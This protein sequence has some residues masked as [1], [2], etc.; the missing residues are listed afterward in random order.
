VN[1]ITPA[2]DFK[3]VFNAFAEGGCRAAVWGGEVRDAVLG[4]ESMDT[5]VGWF[6][7][8]DS[9]LEVLKKNKWGGKFKKQGTCPDVQELSEHNLTCQARDTPNSYV[10][11]GHPSVS[12]EGFE[13]K[14]ASENVNGPD[15]SREFTTNAMAYDPLHAVVI[16]PTGS[17]LCD[18]LSKRVAV[19]G[20]H[21]EGEHTLDLQNVSNFEEWNNGLDKMMRVLK[22]VIPPKSFCI[23]HQTF[24]LVGIDLFL[25]MSSFSNN[26]VEKAL[27]D[28][29]SHYQSR[30]KQLEKYAIQLFWKFCR[31]IESLRNELPAFLQESLKQSSRVCTAVSKLTLINIDKE[32]Q[33]KIL[34]PTSA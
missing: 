30:S 20:L 4:I 5:D 32:V 9:V 24:A 19:A 33:D 29:M 6:C 11:V 2:T 14:S 25:K 16:D 12:D 26:A 15:S 1:G 10:Q 28:I 27:I 3:R 34:C 22:L 23:G 31:S 8:Q 7:G 13:G 17:G 21:E 18:T